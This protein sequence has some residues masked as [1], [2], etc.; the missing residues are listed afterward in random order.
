[1]NG[2]KQIIGVMVLGLAFFLVSA[3]TVTA[4]SVVSD[5]GLYVVSFRSNTEP[6]PIN[7]IHTWV[8]SVRHPDGTP[9]TG[10]SIRIDG[11]MPAHGHGLPTRPEVTEELGNG[12]YEIEGIKFQMPGAWVM[13][14]T[15][16][17]V[18]NSALAKVSSRSY[19]SRHQ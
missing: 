13:D 12:D 6:I 4:T 3:T 16:R 8:L 5:K 15:V 7:R 19:C 18:V 17:L 9:V 1:M 14:F 11:D 2:A 10:A